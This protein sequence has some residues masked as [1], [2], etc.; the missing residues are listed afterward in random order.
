MM[1]DAF[2]YFSFFIFF[3]T[4]QFAKTT[5]VSLIEMGENVHGDAGENDEED[6]GC[7]VGSGRVSVAPVPAKAA[8]A[9]D[10]EHHHPEAD[11]PHHGNKEEGSPGVRHRLH[12]RCTDRGEM[13]HKRLA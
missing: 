11:E 5:V 12:C 2:I 13:Q 10:D 9:G 1:M 3:F 4:L 7:D 8:A 6:E